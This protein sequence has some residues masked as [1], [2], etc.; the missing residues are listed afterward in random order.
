MTSTQEQ[1]NKLAMQFVALDRQLATAVMH[2]IRA[3][4]KTKK[5]TGRTFKV[6]AFAQ[7]IQSALGDTTVGR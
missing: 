1:Y 5:A 4:A 6:L 2:A 7:A 3:W